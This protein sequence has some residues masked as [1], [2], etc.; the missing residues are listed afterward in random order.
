MILDAHE[1]RL[2][3]EARSREDRE[4]VL[5][6]APGRYRIKRVL[7]DRLEVAG[8]ALASGALVDLAQLGYQTAPLSAGIV[9]GDPRDLSPAERHEWERTRAFG[10]LA[11]GQAVSALNMFDRLVREAPG[12]TVAWRGRGRALVRMAEAYQRVNDRVLEQRALTD[13]VKSDPSLT[14]DPAIQSWYQRLGQLGAHDRAAQ[15]ERELDRRAHPRRFQRFVAG[16]GIDLFSVRG[17]VAVSGT[18]VL[19]RAVFSHLAFDIAGFGFDAGVVVAPLSSRWSPYMALGGHVSLHRLGIGDLGLMASD[20]MDPMDALPKY[21]EAIFAEHARLEAGAQ[22][23]Y[24]TG[25]TAELGLAVLVYPDSDGKT[26][27]G[28]F[29]VIH[30]GWL[31]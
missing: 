20:T 31:F 19:H 21:L 12:D 6:L 4:V 15:V 17:L 30:V 5:A 28:G 14:D 11:D 23:V 10:V 8:V 24:P 26:S 16:A 18:A 25:F 7:G 27:T 29:P 3:A 9:K 1:W 2:I 13:A 22:Y